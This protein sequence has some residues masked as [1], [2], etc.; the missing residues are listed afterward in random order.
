AAA[1]TKPSAPSKPTLSAGTVFRDCPTCPEMVVIPAR[2]FVMG[3]PSSEP[4]RES[5]ES[6]Q[7]TV[8]IK[9][10]AAGRFEVTFDE[11]DACVA[12][13]GCETKP[14]DQ[15]W[16]RGK[17][18][19]INVSWSDA[20]AFAGWLSRKTGQRY[21]LLTE[22][23]WEY[24]ARGGTTS[25]YWWGASVGSGNA[26]CNGCGSQ[27]DNAKTG[28]V[29]SFDANPFGL[30]DTSGNV[31]EWVEDCYAETYS[32][33][34]TEGSANTTGACAVRVLRGGSWLS[35][36]RG[37]RSAIRYWDAPAGRYNFL[38]FRLARAL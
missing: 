5:N 8:S 10:F 35:V 17:R 4:N 18:P 37:L 7:R 3:S 6:P 36:P 13:G 38:G 19:V 11:W 1:K 15:G 12:E 33:A 24:A 28:P 30:H 22:A 27:W 23:E 34:S 21:R 25:A 26:N 32:G 9:A 29:G 14:A 16:G 20:K 2:S 31:W